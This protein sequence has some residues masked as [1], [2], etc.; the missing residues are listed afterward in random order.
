MLA[1]AL[2]NYLFDAETHLPEADPAMIL[3]GGMARVRS[4]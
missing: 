2:P 3:G 1:A 4:L